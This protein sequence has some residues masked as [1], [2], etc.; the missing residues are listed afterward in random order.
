MQPILKKYFQKQFSE[1]FFNVDEHVAIAR[2]KRRVDHYLPPNHGVTTDHIKALHKLGYLPVIIKSVAE[3]SRVNIGVPPFTIQPSKVGEEHVWLIGYLETIISCE[4][5]G[6]CTSAT[7]A[8]EYRK[9]LNKWAMLTVGNTDFVKFQGHDFSMRGMYGVEAA[10]MSGSAHLTS[11]VGTDT[12]PAI[13]YVEEYYHADCEKELIGCSVTATEHSVMCLSTG[14]YIWDKYKGDWKHQGEAELAVFRRLITETCPTGI[15][16]IVSDTWDLFRVLT[17]YVVQLKEEILARDGKLVIRPDSGD[18]VDIICGTYNPAIFYTCDDEEEFETI[19]D[20]L[21]D[22]DWSASDAYDSEERIYKFK[23]NLYKVTLS[24]G[25]CIEASWDGTIFSTNSKAEKFKPVITPQTKGVIELLWD[26]FGGTITDKGFKLLDS[27]I[28]AIYGDS[29]T[30]ERAEQICQRLHDKGFA[31][32]NIVF[33]IGSYTYQ[34]QT[35]DTFGGAIKA[36]F[37]RVYNEGGT[38]YDIE[39]FKDPITDDGTKKSARGLIRVNDVGSVDQMTNK[40]VH[41]YYSMSD[42]VSAIEEAGGAL[43][44]VFRDGKLIREF[45]LAFIRAKIEK[46]L[47]EEKD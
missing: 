28:G 6:P 7:I 19:E 27:H 30:L 24:A 37:G 25:D 8:Y 38:P 17:D 12:I 18:P 46:S 23:G 43:E 20:W 47:I 14:F 10:M 45:S 22:V 4:I 11:F 39:I 31:S 40:Y 5:W 35:R 21:E 1:T 13:D 41:Q 42:R 2:F 26:T 36:T 9:I 33:G 34:Y 44:T 15:I 29:I 16:S 3:G 32:I